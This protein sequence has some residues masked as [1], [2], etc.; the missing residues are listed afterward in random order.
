MK[1]VAPKYIACGKVSCNRKSN[2]FVTCAGL[3]AAVRVIKTS[4]IPENGRLEQLIADLDMDAE[5][6][7]LISPDDP[8]NVSEARILGSRTALMGGNR[9]VGS[10][11][12]PVKSVFDDYSQI[13]FS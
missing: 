5:R 8:E 13:E 9:T 7:L 6:S 1:T 11:S 10:K 12:T 3:A 2:Y 4:H